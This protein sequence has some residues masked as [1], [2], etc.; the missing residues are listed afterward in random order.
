MNR[1]DQ[2]YHSESVKEIDEIAFNGCANLTE[3]VVSP[4]NKWFVAENGCLFSK[5]KETLVTYPACQESYVIP[6]GVTT[7]ERYAFRGCKSLT[8]INIPNSVTKI[9]KGAFGYCTSLKNITLSACLKEIDDDI[10][11]P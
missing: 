10:K 1:L 5:G 2:H 8:S 4:G 11:K 6:D 7:I 9:G 3:L